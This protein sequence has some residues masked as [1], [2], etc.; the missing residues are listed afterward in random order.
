MRYEN[1]EVQQRL[2]RSYVVGTLCEAA[3]QRVETL[4]AEIPALDKRVRDWEAHLQP[5]ADAV[6]E[7]PPDPAL[8]DRIDASLN[9]PAA[10]PAKPW[11][12]SLKLLRGV[13]F[14]SSLAAIGLA[15]L[16]LYPGTSPIA[17][18]DY[19]AVLADSDG[20]PRF[21]ATASEATRNF[22]IRVFGEPAP[23]AGTDYQLW[24]IS[25]TD[26]EARSLGLLDPGTASQRVLSDS[27]WRLITDARELLV[28]AEMP[29][30]SAI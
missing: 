6:P 15:M 10:R 9:A 8:W 29:G 16:L 5:L 24:A 7:L 12:S 14:A 22:D 19:V 21:V 4:R 28:T 1:P 30:G 18:I 26:G 2:A 23:S 17:E 25:K 13:A 20:E 3:R 27:D 11:W